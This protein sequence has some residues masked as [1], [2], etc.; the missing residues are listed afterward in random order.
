MDVV[1]GVNRRIERVPER[2][3][4]GSGLFAKRDGFD[5]MESF[6]RGR[7]RAAYRW[8][9]ANAIRAEKSEQPYPETHHFFFTPPDILKKKYL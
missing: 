6:F 2:H 3:R 9:G 1:N 5:E 4:R 8:N 7:C